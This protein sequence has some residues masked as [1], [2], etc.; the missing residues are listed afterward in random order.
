M[1]GRN[2]YIC[3]FF[4][5]CFLNKSRIDHHCA[6]MGN[7]IGKRNR[8]IFIFCLIIILTFFCLLALLS[9][10]KLQDELHKPPKTIY[11]ALYLGFFSSMYSL[12]GGFTLFLALFHCHLIFTQKTTLEFLFK[13]YAE[14]ENPFDKGCWKNLSFFLCKTVEKS[15]IDLEYLMRVEESELAF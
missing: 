5:K 11:R 14:K 8:R 10:W 2:G 1:C 13:T 3:I 12:S 15:E 6:W 7:C 9:I 4:D